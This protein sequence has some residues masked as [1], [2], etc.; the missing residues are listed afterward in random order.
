MNFETQVKILKSHEIN[1][2]VLKFFFYFLFQVGETEK[3]SERKKIQS[4]CFKIF[5]F[6]IYKL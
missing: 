6:N 2:I 5:I 3:N 1:N 4:R